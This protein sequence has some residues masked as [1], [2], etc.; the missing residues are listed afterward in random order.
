MLSLL[1]YQSVFRGSPVGELLLTP[2]ACIADVNEA[3]LKASSRTRSELVG[4]NL[5]DVFPENPD[6]LE[7]TGVSALRKSL[8]RVVASGQPDT[9][10]LQ[11]Y[12]ISV[13]LPDGSSRYEERFWSAVN[14]PILDEAGQLLCIS[15]STMDVTD[16]QAPTTDAPAPDRLARLEAGAFTRAQ[17]L[18][19]VNKALQEERS[20]LRHLFDHAPGFVY[21]TRGPEHVIEQGNKAFDDLVGG[22]E[23]VGRKLRDAFPD[24]QTQ[25]LLAWHDEVFRSGKPYL[26]NARRVLLP[27]APG[28]PVVEHFVDLVY[29]PIFDEQG[30]VTG[31]CGQGND[32]TEKIRVEVELRRQSARRAFQLEL[33]DRIRSLEAPEEIVDVGSELLGRELDVARV[34]YCE[35][36][37]AQ[38]TF[39]VRRDWLHPGYALSSIAGQVR[40]LDDFGPENTAVLRAGEVM[41]VDDIEA[42][43][44]TRAYAQAYASIGVRAKLVIPLVK[45]GRL[46]V[47]LSLHHSHPY[48]WTDDDVDNCRYT[49][50]RTWG[51]VGKAR[52][53]AEL[54]EEGR[55]KDEFLAMLAHELRNPLAPISAAAQLM[56]MGPLD[57]DRIKQTSHVISRQVSHMTGLID[58]L[59]D[60]SRVTRGLVTLHTSPQDLKSVISSAVEQVRPLIE[61]QRHHLAIDL[62]PEPAHVQGDSK[63]LVQIFANLLNN[64][65]KY[66]PPGG[67]LSVKAEVGRDEIVVCVEDNGIGIAPDLHK[68]V[69]D[70]FAQAERTADRS[71]G[72][73]GLGLPLA[74]SLVELHGGDLSCRSDGVG[75]GSTFIVRLPRLVQENAGAQQQ[76]SPGVEPAAARL[77]VLVV[78]DNADAAEMMAIL[79]ETAGHEVVVEHSGQAALRRA[80]DAAPDVC[81]LDIGLPDMDGKELARRLRQQQETRGTVLIAVTGYGQEQDRQ[82]ALAAGFDHHMV[83]PADPERLTALLNEIGEAQLRPA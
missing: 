70:L 39:F 59:L 28:G 51:A 44:R 19:A 7:D 41:R 58:D 45:A 36:D 42:D 27:R 63:R 21:F 65:A 69:F 54:Q 9:I 64:A 11:R 75:K 57:A 67:R 4:R 8:A 12:P 81:L 40:R 6:D 60:V 72:G 16:L 3:F 48:H 68:H 25:E 13:T 2:D 82:S 77:K 1:A 20:R 32:I 80:R 29:Q 61:S 78:D 73:L 37:D 43:P 46:R 47:V 38:Q 17:T 50:E 15:H 79:L 26:A 23:V 71:Q 74:K 30:R 10:A 18:Q 56:Q 62:P 52:A 22:R 76:D 49:A 14:T 5:F 66:T 53:Q 34:L 35:I 31:I 55:R 83:K 33:S 24:A